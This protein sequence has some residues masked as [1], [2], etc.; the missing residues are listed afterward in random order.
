MSVKEASE[1]LEKA[2]DNMCRKTRDL[3]RQLRKAVV[4]HV[5]G[6]LLKTTERASVE[7]LFSNFWPPPPPLSLFALFVY[8]FSSVSTLFL[9]FYLSP[10]HC[11]QGLLLTIDPKLMALSHPWLGPWLKSPWLPHHTTLILLVTWTTMNLNHNLSYHK[12]DH[13]E[14]Y[15]NANIDDVVKGSLHTKYNLSN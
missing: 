6:R 11:E 13:H 10:I 14:A 9:S 8:S 15:E 1:G 3:R 2:I 12:P 4:D 5:S 7:P